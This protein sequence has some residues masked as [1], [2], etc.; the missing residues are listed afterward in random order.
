[1]AKKELAIWK[2]VFSTVESTYCA[3]KF[4]RRR[5]VGAHFRLKPKSLVT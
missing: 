1:M 2:S 3:S 4:M 5:S